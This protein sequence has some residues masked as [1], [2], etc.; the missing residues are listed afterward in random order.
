VLEINDRGRSRDPIKGVSSLE[1]PAWG[2]HPEFAL[3]YAGLSVPIRAPTM[4]RS[5]KSSSSPPFRRKPRI[6]NA[7]LGWTEEVLEARKAKKRR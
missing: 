2:V 6:V 3:H 4:V 5:G 7:Q 1:L